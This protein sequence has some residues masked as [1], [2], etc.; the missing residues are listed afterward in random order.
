[1]YFI[2]SLL[3]A[4]VFAVL[5]YLV[6]YCTTRSEGGVRAFGQVLTVW[7]FIIALLFLLTGAYISIAGFSPLEAHFQEMH[8]QE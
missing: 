4:T 5:G 8:G 1:M 7:V 6:L 2:F 3:P